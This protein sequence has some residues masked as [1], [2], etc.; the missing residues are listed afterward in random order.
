MRAEELRIGDWVKLKTDD[1]TFIKVGVF[2]L[3]QESLLGFIDGD[4]VLDEIS[5]DD[6]EPI[7]LTADLLYDNLFTPTLEDDRIYEY[8]YGGHYVVRV[9]KDGEFIN[10]ADETGSRDDEDF[11]CDLVAMISATCG[12]RLAVHN[13]QHFLTENYIDIK[14][15]VKEI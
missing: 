6:V 5:Y 7:P 3:Q 13:L 2:Q 15:K 12:D 1:K 14:I 9:Q 10:L 4:K 8:C 11:D